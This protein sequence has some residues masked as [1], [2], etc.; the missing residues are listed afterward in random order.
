[1]V[2]SRTSRSVHN[3]VV[4]LIF[5]AMT[6]V[7][8]FFSRKVFLDY[9]G[10]E[11]LGLNTTSSNL[12]QFLNL[13][14]LGIGTAV[15]Y[16]LYKP[17]FDDDHER[18]CDIVTLQGWIYRRIALVLIICSG[19]LMC[20]FPLIFRSME[21][22]MWYAYATFGVQLFGALLDYYVNYPLG[23]LV[24]DQKDYKYILSYKAVILLKVV[25]QMIAVS[26]LPFGYVW[27]LAIE[28]LFAILAS[29]SLRRTIRRTYPYLRKSAKSVGA[30]RK[31]YP[32]MFLKV[33]QIFYH[34]LGNFTVSQS[35]PLVIYGFTTLSVVTLYGNYMI[36]VYAVTSLVTAMFSSMG[37]A[38]GSLVAEGDRNRIL[39]VFGELFS[40]RFLFIATLTFAVMFGSPALVTVWIGP[41]YVL[42]PLT[43]ALICINMYIYVSRAT[44]DNFLLAYGLYS[45]IYSPLAEVILNVGLSVL[46]GWKFG[47]D[48]ILAG[49]GVSLF[50]ILFCWNPY[51]LFTRGFRSSLVPYVKLYGRHLLWGCLAAALPLLFL[52]WVS[53]FGSG[54]WGTLGLVAVGCILYFMILSALV[55]LTRSG[56]DRFLAR[57]RKK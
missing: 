32:E 53:S 49:V 55:L 18:I 36:I 41:E 52:R 30:L 39:S 14:E 42:P 7:V 6:F 20:F 4:A 23:V 34:K 35:A 45:D 54:P 33:R 56:A 9:L 44:V 28:A 57:F 50:V 17:L 11:I 51:Y 24:A 10:T 37:G 21:L 1:M 47:L 27:W 26:L 25:V 19:I 16:M 3:S 8:Q 15:G 2:E 38:V 22:P 29:A 12:L 31:E 48:G 13:A 43:V 40:V 46:L 5:F